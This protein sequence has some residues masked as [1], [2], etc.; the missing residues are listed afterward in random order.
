MRIGNVLIL[1]VLAAAPIGQARGEFVPGHVYVAATSPEGCFLPFYAN[2]RVWDIDPVTGE[3]SIL[4]EVPDELCGFM[5]DLEFTP[6][7]TGLRAS[8][9][10]I[11]SVLEFGPDGNVAVALDASD[12]LAQPDGLAYDAEGNFYVTVVSPPRILKFP[13]DGGPAT[14]F[15]DESDGLGSFGKLAFA[16][17]GDLYYGRVSPAQILR[18]TPEGTGELFDTLPGAIECLS[19][20]AQGHLFVLTGGLY[21]YDVGDANSQVL[22]AAGFETG[23]VVSIAASPDGS[24]V[25][26]AT[27]HQLLSFDAVTGSMTT[28][29]EVPDDP[30]AMSWF[31]SGI[32]VYVPEP[33]ALAACLTVVGWACLRR[34]R[35]PVGP[36]ATAA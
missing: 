5:Q 33:S 13:A 9:R 22:L 18:F 17:N 30:L 2:D 1:G 26:M 4:G 24:S 6:D 28:L 11:H 25:Y 15:A 12:G 35:R 34:P 32:A 21:R 36:M 14:V 27:D 8:E 29:A 16:P 20:D 3:S 19:T 23:P 7:G 31:G 10:F